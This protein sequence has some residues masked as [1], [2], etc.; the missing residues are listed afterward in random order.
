MYST[1]PK[2][3]IERYLLCFEPHAAYSWRLCQSTVVAVGCIGLFS[4]PPQLHHPVY[5]PLASRF[6]SPFHEHEIQLSS[7]S[8]SFL[9]VAFSIHIFHAGNVLC[10]TPAMAFWGNAPPSISILKRVLKRALLDF[11]YYFPRFALLVHVSEHVSSF[12]YPN[13]VWAFR[14]NRIW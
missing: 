8:W 6:P 14:E 12:H 5:Q 11:V 7:F 2:A 4:Q 9:T 13:E 3:H 10:S 1:E